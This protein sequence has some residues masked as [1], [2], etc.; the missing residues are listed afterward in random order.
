MKE[1]MNNIEENWE[2]LKSIMREHTNMTEEDIT[3]LTAKN[4]DV[5]YSPQKAIEK[6]V[7][8]KLI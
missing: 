5:I 3:N 7:V 2:V 6:G 4:V 8:D 1:R